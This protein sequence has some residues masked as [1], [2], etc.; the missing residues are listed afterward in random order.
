MDNPHPNIAA[1]RALNAMPD[2]AREMLVEFYRGQAIDKHE[3]DKRR[4]PWYGRF[5][6]WLF[7]SWRCGACKAA[8]KQ[9]LT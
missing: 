1:Y 6:H 2:A 5:Q 8:K 9:R 7:C 4:W 3:A